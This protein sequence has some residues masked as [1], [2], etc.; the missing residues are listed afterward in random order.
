MKGKV[1]GMAF[2]VIQATSN[3]SKGLFTQ[4]LRLI[5]PPFKEPTGGG[6]EGDS[7][8]GRASEDQSP[9]VENSEGPNFAGNREPDSSSGP[10]FGDTSGTGISD[11]SPADTP[12]VSDTTDSPTPSLASQKS[13]SNPPV[14]KR[15]V[16]TNNGVQVQDDDGSYDKN[17]IERLKARAEANKTP[18]SSVQREEPETKS[19]KQTAP[20]LPPTSQPQL[21]LREN[22]G[23]TWSLQS[24]RVFDPASYKKD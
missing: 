15:S 9:S 12:S 4:D 20:R 8:S 3:F 6:G 10:S 14:S 2:M 1:K 7:E 21:K 16:P 17:E 23:E 13:L 19:Q 5:L 24:F 18:P 11:N 22:K